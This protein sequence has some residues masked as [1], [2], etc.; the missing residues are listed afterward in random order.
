[1]HII[2]AS[3]IYFAGAENES[4]LIDHSAM[5]QKWKLIYIDLELLVI[6]WFD[7]HPITHQVQLAWFGFG[8]KKLSAQFVSHT[9][10]SV[11]QQE[12]NALVFFF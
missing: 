1:M 9:K 4:H 5:N 10:Y 7:K 12:L 2:S 8:C 6:N 3:L 11:S